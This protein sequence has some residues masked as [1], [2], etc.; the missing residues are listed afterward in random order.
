MT[1]LVK[2]ISF[3]GLLMLYYDRIYLNAGIIV[4]KSENSKECI[5][6][7]Y[8]YLNHGFI[9]IMHINVKNRICNFSNSLIKWGKLKTENILIDEKSDTLAVTQ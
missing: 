6:C 7:H 9:C 5:V 8:W 2:L 3:W 4:A 1:I